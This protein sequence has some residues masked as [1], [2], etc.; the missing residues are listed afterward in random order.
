MFQLNKV[1]NNEIVLCNIR[2]TKN[3]I[4]SKTFLGIWLRMSLNL[5]TKEKIELASKNYSVAISFY[6]N[7]G[8]TTLNSA[9]LGLLKE[10]ER[11]NNRLLCSLNDLTLASLA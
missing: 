5:S 9:L 3:G 10:A 4:L 7:K 2:E 6:K 8:Y 1:V 11:E